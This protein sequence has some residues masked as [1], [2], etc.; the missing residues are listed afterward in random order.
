M[1]NRP[2]E[3]SLPISSTNYR[4]TLL[5]VVNYFETVFNKPIPPPKLTSYRRLPSITRVSDVYSEKDT[6]SDSEVTDSVNKTPFVTSSCRSSPTAIHRLGNTYI[7]THFTFIDDYSDSDDTMSSNKKGAKKAAVV[8]DDEDRKKGLRQSTIAK[9]KNTDVLSLVLAAIPDFTGAGGG[10]KVTIP[11]PTTATPEG[12]STPSSKGT[13]EPTLPAAFHTPKGSGLQDD[14]IDYA[15]SPSQQQEHLLLQSQIV[16]HRGAGNDPELQATFNDPVHLTIPPDTYEEMLRQENE[17][18]ARL[19]NKSDGLQKTIGIETV[20]T[21]KRKNNKKHKKSQREGDESDSSSSTSV[22]SVENMEEGTETS[23]VRKPLHPASRRIADMEQKMTQLYDI[24]GNMATRLGICVENQVSTESA[25][26]SIAGLSQDNTTKIAT[27][28]AVI[29]DLQSQTGK[30]E[31]QVAAVKNLEAETRIMKQKISELEHASEKC[32][33]RISVMADSIDNLMTSH[34]NM[35]RGMDGLTEQVQH[36]RGTPTDGENASSTTDNCETG[37]FLSGIQQFMEYF[38]M[39]NTTDPF[40]VAGR[41]MQEIGSYGAISRV[42]IADRAADRNERYKARAVIIYFN[43]AF[44]KRQAV[45]ELKKLLQANPGLRATVSDVFPVAETP[46][47]LALT[48]YAADKRSDRSMTRTRV[49]NKKGNAVLQHT[50]GASK[51]YKDSTISESDLQPYYQPR[52]G[53]ARE[54]QTDRR[55]HNRNDQARERGERGRQVDRRD[56]NSRNEREFRDQDRADQRGN[57][58]S[59]QFFTNTNQGQHQQ[60]LQLPQRA[61]HQ[62]RNTPPLRI[63]TPN[64]HPI[65]NPRQT[66]IS[67]PTGNQQQQPPLQQHPTYNQQQDPTVTVPPQQLQQHNMQ[68]TFHDNNTVA[69]SQWFQGANGPPVQQH[70]SY[71]QVP[72]SLIPFIQQQIYGHQQQMQQQQHQLQQNYTTENNGQQLLMRNE[73]TNVN[74]DG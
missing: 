36:V 39:R 15:N 20:S 59:T 19:S 23:T 8:S 52:E 67:L 12:L 9:G 58:N 2:S 68:P 1:K 47:A 26:R 18:Q 71:L 27:Q 65:N 24:V 50:E 11:T 53:G 5:D 38:D 62:R 7:N 35:K 55:E 70:G 56:G 66:S 25:V 14:S 22:A 60:Q 61:G 51:E 13:Q 30:I 43:S 17:R 34:D 40:L 44:H 31:T 28:G 42:F 3:I 16:A 6:A 21:P 57:N 72:Q 10:K 63:S 4:K 73:A 49:V 74:R 69:N 48:R 32:S 45:I 64:K 46:R 37:I 29:R 33:R 54:R 41:L